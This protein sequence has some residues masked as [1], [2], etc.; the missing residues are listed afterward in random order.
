MTVLHVITGLDNGGAEG[1]LFR[2]ARADRAN[3]HIV[4]SM[5]DTGVYGQRFMDAGIA[6]HAAA[7]PRG[8]ISVAGLR[9]VYRLIRLAN[10]DVVQTWMYH[11]DI[12]GGVLARLAGRRAIAWGVR[13][14]DAHRHSPRAVN[15]LVRIGAACSYLIPRRILFNSAAG[16]YWHLRAGYSSSRSRIV[17]NGYD[18]DALR[19]DAGARRRQRAAWGLPEATVVFGTVARWDPLKDHTTLAAALRRLAVSTTAAWCCVLVGPGMTP[20]NPQAAALFA[21]PELQGHIIL[22]GPS[23][24]VSAVMNAFDVHVLSSKSEAFPNVLPEAMACGTPC[25]ATNVGDAA[26]IVGATGWIVPAAT[27]DALAGALHEALDELRH[28][29]GWEARRSACRSAIVERFS[30]GAMVSAYNR[31]WREAIVA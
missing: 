5:T 13:A 19:P 14:A 21:A 4:I 6:V 31:I 24:D 16:S 26:D 11:A 2:L 20:A 7:M 28:P 23:D 3:T 29:A 30:I 8:R 1:A 25:V 9:R 17:P 15:A 12:A 10:P 27:P 18:T 22:A